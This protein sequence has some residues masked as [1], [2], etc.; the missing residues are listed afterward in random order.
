M[1]PFFNVLSA[2]EVETVVNFVRGV[3]GLVGTRSRAIDYDSDNVN[4]VWRLGDI[5]HSTPAVAGTV[6]R[7]APSPLPTIGRPYARASANAMPYPSSADAKTNI[8][9]AP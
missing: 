7:T 3:E 1:V 5:V 8:S 2:T 4:E 6:S 9:A